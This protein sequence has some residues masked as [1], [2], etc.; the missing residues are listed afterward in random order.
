MIASERRENPRNKLKADVSVVTSDASLSG[1]LTEISYGGVIAAEASLS[2]MLTEISSGGGGIRIQASKSINPGINI[3]VC[4]S[5]PHNRETVLH[6]K[7]IWALEL[8]GPK[9]KIYHMGIE[10]YEKG[11]SDG[12]DDIFADLTDKILT[13]PF[14]S[15]S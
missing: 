12:D 7:V 3:K 8:P 15:L 1:M 13:T 9:Q 14:L 2:D 6:G 11:R 10:I 5:P 4:I